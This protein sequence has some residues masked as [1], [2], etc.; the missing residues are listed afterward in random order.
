MYLTNQIFGTDNLP[1]PLCG[2]SGDMFYYT[3]DGEKKI[4]TVI[5]R[6]DLKSRPNILDP[7]NPQPREKE[8][9]VVYIFS[10]EN[11]HDGRCAL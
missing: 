3:I 2:S 4:P 8:S 11:D 7:A 9:K 5:E 10:A 6:D 1:I